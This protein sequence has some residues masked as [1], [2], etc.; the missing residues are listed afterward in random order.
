MWRSRSG[1]PISRSASSMATP[2]PVAARKHWDLGTRQ[3]MYRLYADPLRTANTDAGNLVGEWTGNA[4]NPLSGPGWT[5]TAATMPDNALVGRDG[6]YRGVGAVAERQLQLPPAHRYRRRVRHGRAAGEQPEGGGVEPA[7][8]PDPAL[9][10]GGWVAAAGQR[11]A[12]HLPERLPVAGRLHRRRPDDL[13][14]HVRV[15]P[16]PGAELDRPADLRR[17]LRLR[18]DGPGE[19]A[20]RDRSQPVLRHGRS[21]HAGGLLGLPVHGGIRAPIPRAR[22]RR[23][24]R[25][26]T[27]TWTSTGAAS[28]AMPCGWAACATR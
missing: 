21:G 22:S 8:L 3:L 20:V 19:L 9:R 28:R 18:H 16:Q 17:R 13:R 7:E 11:R 26:T 12:D 23:R 1:R 24:R 10:P 27:T 2:V 5:V 4:A 25:R 15:L 14:R 6:E